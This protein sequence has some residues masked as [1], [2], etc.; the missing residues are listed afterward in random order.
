LRQQNF[1]KRFK[2]LRVARLQPGMLP[3]SWDGTDIEQAGSIRPFKF[4]VR[5]KKPLIINFTSGTTA[6]VANVLDKSLHIIANHSFGAALVL[7]YNAQLRFV[8]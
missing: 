7:N 2:V 6:S 3:I 4:F 8:G 5:F 1:L